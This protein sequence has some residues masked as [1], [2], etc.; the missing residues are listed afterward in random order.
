MQIVVCTKWAITGS[1]TILILI[2]FQLYSHVSPLYV[3]FDQNLDFSTYILLISKNIFRLC[4]IVVLVIKLLFVSYNLHFGIVGCRCCT[5]CDV[6]RRSGKQILTAIL[7]FKNSYFWISNLSNN[8]SNR[9]IWEKLGT[10]FK[11][12][13]IS[14][15]TYGE[16]YII[17]NFVV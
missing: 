1:C 15:S 2:N 10:I 14:I 13:Y 16:A 3:K 12:I 17:F 8:S 9:Q 7:I 11:D 6:L 5:T 4:L